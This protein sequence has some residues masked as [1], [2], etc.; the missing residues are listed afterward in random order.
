[1]AYKQP[2]KQVNKDNDGASVVPFL[3]A[4]P[5]LVA[6]IGTALKVGG[7]A[8]KAATTAAKVGKATATAAKGTK[9]A[10]TAAKTGKAFTSGG[11][12]IA[13][14][15]KITKSAAPT[16][17]TNITSSVAKSST[18]KGL[19]KAVAKAGEVGKDL[20]AKGKEVVGKAKE[21]VDKFKQGYDKAAGKIANKTGFE[22][23]FIKEKG[24]GL[25][26]SAASSVGD[27]ISSG[28]SGVKSSASKPVN[29]SPAERDNPSGIT[30]RKSG[31]DLEKMDG[32]NTADGVEEFN[33]GGP[34]MFDYRKN[35]GPS[36]KSK[37]NNV[38]Y[39]A[40]GPHDKIAPSLDED[41]TE[42]NSFGD[43]SI[44]NF[45]APITIKGV[46]FDAGDVMRLGI[47]G[48]KAGK[49][50]VENY[51]HEHRGERALR[52]HDKA[53]KKSDTKKYKEMKSSIK[54]QKQINK[55]SSNVPQM[56]LEDKR[57]GIKKYNDYK[58][59]FSGDLSTAK[60][61]K[62]QIKNITSNMFTGNTK[63]LNKKN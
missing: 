24:A 13:K 39:G 12:V 50:G 49:K 25:A 20:A 57:K 35:H 47:M 33:Q 7:T 21:G 60:K 46:T 61:N 53:L 11:K 58:D 42:K 4:I 23:E 51:R 5:A 8:A 43:M 10:A 30:P 29:L 63:S 15:A 9:A 31:F 3:A 16:L 26:S 19:G 37:Y 55:L 6:K 28:G 1:M 32:I 27:K 22:K 48:Y 52:K 14:G 56:S 40:S 38:N 62:K 59:F 54:N 18:K 36:I 41:N 44:G 2:Y 17:K 34:S 45:S